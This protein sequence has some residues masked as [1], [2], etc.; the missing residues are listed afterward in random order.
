[1]GVDFFP[2]DHCGDSICDCGSYWTCSGEC[3]ARLCD[4]CAADLVS[5]EDNAEACPFCRKKVAT[6]YQLLEFA[7]A[8]LGVTRDELMAE[9]KGPATS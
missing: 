6:D 7:L 5:D 2:C 9:Y 3:G 8:K 4:D 1:M